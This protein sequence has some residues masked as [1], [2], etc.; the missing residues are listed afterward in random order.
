[1]ADQIRRIRDIRH[2]L[3]RERAFRNRENPLEN[4][5]AEEVRRRS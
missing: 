5:P 2:A 4:L 3:G 1:M